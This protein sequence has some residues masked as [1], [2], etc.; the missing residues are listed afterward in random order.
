MSIDWTQKAEKERDAGAEV[1]GFQDYMELFE[2]NPKRETRPTFNYLDDMLEYFGKD[3]QDNYKLFDIMHTDA[4]AVHGQ[5]KI[6][7]S[8]VSNLK[9][10][11]EEG[12]NNKFILLVGPNGSS[13]SS[14]VKKLMRGAEEY[15]QSDE[16]ALYTFSWIFPID[17]FVKGSLGL[18][19]TPT[20]RNISTYAYLEDKDISAILPSELKD[21]PLLLIPKEYRQ[22]VFTDVFKG[23]ESQLETIKKN[24]LFK[25]DLSKRNRMIYDA[26]LKNY[27]GR[28]K[29][30]LKHIRVERFFIS[31]RY[32][33]AAVTIEPQMHV[34]A[35]MQQ[36]TMDKRLGSL[37]PSL[38]SLNLYS[39]QGEAVMANRGMLEY[40]DLLKRPLDT[41]KYLLMTMESSTLNLQGILTE[42]DIFFIGTSNEV[43]LAA[44]K[45]HPDFN[46]FKG[47]FNFIKVPYLLNYIEEEK[48]YIEQVEG[49]SDS[50]L[51]EPHALRALC[52]FAVMTR[53]RA[54][55]AK[56]F[57]DK[58]LAEILSSLNPLEKSRFY[59]EHAIP[60]RFDSEA[61]QLM[62]QSWNEA[63]EEFE[64]DNLYQGK[65]GLSPR[66]IK[67]IIYKLTSRYK[68]VTFVEVLE[69]LQRL[70]T[71]KNDYDFLNMT[72]QAD[73]HHPT[74]FLALIKDYCLDL[75]DEEVRACLGL[76]DER[77][78]DE[79]ITRYVLNV[80]ALI[81]G[82]KIKNNITGKYETGD[83]YFIKEFEQSI[84][85]KEDVSKFRSHL[86]SKLGAH[87]LDN[88]GKPINYSEVFPD[89]VRR[90][91][92]SFRSEQKKVIETISRNL[93]F[94]EAELSGK[95]QGDEVSTPLSE[96]NR[97]QIHQV[98]NNLVSNFKYTTSGAIRLLQFL[99][100]ERY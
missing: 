41:Y 83:D 74:R 56:N 76:V 90:L 87:Y 47:R 78:Y 1:L 54:S 36:I 75:A 33:N 61:R 69:Y 84:S 98:V 63:M 82:E 32:S 92:E 93:V 50:S 3:K 68:V 65:F 95:K 30:V 16:G 4:P 14:I 34:D 12:F 77:S 85:L 11:Q 24:Y 25:G 53:L 5:F 48:I 64:N 58:K 91:Q 31:R 17:S 97:K 73:F 80:N 60:E 81:K 79:Y 46:S 71:K 13:K 57:E 37:P 72:A 19:S 51:F 21:H 44:F 6:I 70:I 23:D 28:H 7:K 62:S 9:N 55:L 26:L 2:A 40:S 49:L 94:F 52:L 86:I 15:S 89:L 67:S 8:I 22:E 39:L 27:K 88:P 45:Q 66:D 38:Q 18:A 29:E 20:D 96:E 59:A 35:R 43:H 10:F 42:L 99:I 100:K